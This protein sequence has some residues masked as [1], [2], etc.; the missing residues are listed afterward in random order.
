KR[1]PDSLLAWK[2]HERCKRRA[3]PTALCLRLQRGAPWLTRLVCYVW[4]SLHIYCAQYLTRAS[5]EL[6]GD[7]LQGQNG[8]YPLENRQYLA[9]DHVTRDGGFLRIAPATVQ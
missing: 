7:H 8:A 9:I 4:N 5:E 6:A 1:F 3:V 2:I